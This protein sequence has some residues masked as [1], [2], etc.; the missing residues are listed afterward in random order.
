MSDQDASRKYAILLT[1]TW[2]SAPTTQGYT[3]WSRDVALP[4]GEYFSSE[5]SIEVSPGVIDGG[6]EDKPWKVQMEARLPLNNLV[7]PSRFAPV[8][9]RIEE[10][11]PSDLSS[12]NL[13]F[14]GIIATTVKNKRNQPKL[15]EFQ[16][17][18]L[19]TKLKIPLGVISSNECAWVFGRP[20]CCYDVVAIQQTANVTSIVNDTVITLDDLD[21]PLGG[22]ARWAAGSVERDGLTIDIQSAIDETTLLLAEVPPPEWD[23]APVLLTPGCD[24]ALST[25]R[26]Y[27][28]EENFGGMGIR[29]PDHNPL[30]GSNT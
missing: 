15:V 16:V 20:P 8:T 12:R 27:N 26:L 17:A 14:Q 24:G 29:M 7:R 25:C 21:V 23:G 9:C 4:G 3:S 11:D 22:I 5:P 30:I 13:L 28:N 1:F 18:G 6:V 19:R 10:I 2:G